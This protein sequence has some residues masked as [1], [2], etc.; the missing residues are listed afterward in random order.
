MLK[1]KATAKVHQKDEVVSNNNHHKRRTTYL[2][3]PILL[4]DLGLKPRKF[5]PRF[6]QQTSNSVILGKCNVKTSQF[7]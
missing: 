4:T 6:K 5:N 2:A 7:V 3:D 1:F